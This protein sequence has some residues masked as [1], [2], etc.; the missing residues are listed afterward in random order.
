MPSGK[1]LFV[2]F[3]IITILH[4]DLV[5]RRKQENRFGLNLVC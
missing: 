4:S 1:Y 2:P 3:A 5:V